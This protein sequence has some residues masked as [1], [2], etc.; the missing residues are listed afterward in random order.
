MARILIICWRKKV[1]KIIQDLPVSGLRRQVRSE[2]A[3]FPHH[4]AGVAIL[5]VRLA[6]QH[7]SLKN[8]MQWGGHTATSGVEH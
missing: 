2:A 4:G 8:A 1:S 6:L 7:W 5:R 3:L